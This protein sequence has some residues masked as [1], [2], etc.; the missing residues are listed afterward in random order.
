M[1]AN[2]I[3]PILTFNFVVSGNNSTNKK[4][5]LDFAQPREESKMSKIVSPIIE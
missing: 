5:N 1:F 3:E 2:E 4:I